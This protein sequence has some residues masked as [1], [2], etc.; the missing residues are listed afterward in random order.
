MASDVVGNEIDILLLLRY[1][2]VVD[3]VETSETFTVNE[4]YNL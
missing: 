2:T 1:V 4:N 3:G